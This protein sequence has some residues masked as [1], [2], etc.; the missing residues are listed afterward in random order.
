MRTT[1]STPATALTKAVLVMS[2]A[3]GGGMGGRPA[4]MQALDKTWRSRALCDM[5]MSDACWKMTDVGSKDGFTWTPL[6]KTV[7]GPC[8]QTLTCGHTLTSG[9]TRIG[10]D[11]TVLSHACQAMTANSHTLTSGQ[12]T[13]PGCE[14]DLGQTRRKGKSSSLDRQ[15]SMALAASSHG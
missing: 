13:L 12:T 7:S 1:A 4:L 5:P 15:H 2:W 3:K 14:V 11:A 9:Q 6:K 10:A 8:L